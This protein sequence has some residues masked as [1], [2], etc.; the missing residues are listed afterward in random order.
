MLLH[1][2]PWAFSETVTM[3]FP[4]VF[5]LNPFFHFLPGKGRNLWLVC[6]G[7]LEGVWGREQWVCTLSYSF[8]WF[9]HS[10]RSACTASGLRT[11]IFMPCMW[12]SVQPFSC[13]WGHSV[14]PSGPL[15]TLQFL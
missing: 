3:A 6:V 8:L 1:Y 2:L 14:Q 10:G 15:G 12:S 9:D 4:C 7:M 11:W 5:G 13:V